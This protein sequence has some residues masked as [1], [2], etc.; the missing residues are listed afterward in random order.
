L[1]NPLLVKALKSVARWSDD[2]DTQTAC[3]IDTGSHN[4]VTGTN[5]LPVGVE[6]SDERVTRPA[7]YDW[8][9]HAERVAI[10]KAAKVGERT[11]GADMYLNWFPCAG[12]AQCIVEAGISTLYADR[13]A[14]EARK[15]DPRYGFDIAMAMLNEG[16]V[17]IEWMEADGDNVLQAA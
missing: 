14:Y 12:C 16:G 1:I 10:S 9:N 6:K 13:Q 7:K 17:R 15:D 11:N 8:I 5:R 2:P 4:P 3:I